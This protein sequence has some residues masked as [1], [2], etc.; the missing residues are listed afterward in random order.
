MPEGS[1]GT[2]GQSAQ[3][4]SLADFQK[5]QS[6]F[7]AAQ[8][9]IET[10][11]TNSRKHEGRARENSDAAKRLKEL[12][13]SKGTDTEKAIRAAVSEA[14]AK[15]RTETNTKL[16][17]TTLKT[18]GAAKLGDKFG[19]ILPGINVNAFLDEDG[20]TNEQAIDDFLDG[21]APEQPRSQGFD[22]GQGPR[23]DGQGSAS[24]AGDGLTKEVAR[25]A[26]I[27]I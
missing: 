22:F 7:A 10:W 20:N 9:E 4:V 16:A 18:K 26:G 21:L 6:D 3:T 17:M 14:E 23:G 11:K 13:D 25:L 15:W 19:K 5:L 1:E 24:L 2:E 27:K 8:Q 12:E